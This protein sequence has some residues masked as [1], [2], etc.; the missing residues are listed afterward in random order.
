MT[1]AL[2]V[3]SCDG[4]GGLR[5]VESSSFLSPA[6]LD[7]GTR[8][9]GRTHELTT[10]LSNTSAE[11]LRVF[12]VRLTP[13]ENVY[14]ARLPTETLRGALLPRGS[15]NTV[16]VIFNPQEERSYDTTLTIVFGEF[17]VDLPITASAELIPP[18]APVLSPSRI[19]FPPT[20]VGRDVFQT[21]RVTN[22]GQTDGVLKTVKGANAPFSVEA[23]GGGTLILPS[24]VLRPGGTRDLEVHFRPTLA[25]QSLGSIELAF[26]T[27]ELAILEVSGEGAAAGTM[28]CTG[29]IDFGAV[30]RGTTA[31][32]DA[33]CRVSGGA[34]TLREVRFTSASSSLFRIPVVPA[35]VAGDGSLPFQI[36]FDAAG[37][38]NQHNATIEIVAEHGAVTQLNLVGVV[39]PP[40]PG[41]TDMRVR[42]DWNT[43]WSD[44]DI[45]LVRNSV[46]FD[47]DDDCYFA[48]KNPDWGDG[49][50][51]VDDPFL[52][53]DDVDGFGPEE[54][55]LT[56]VDDTT[57]VYDLWVQYHHYSRSTAPP[58]TVT[59]T[60]EIRNFGPVVLTR[61]MVTCGNIWHVGQFRFDQPTP[62]FN[63][64]DVETNDYQASAGERCR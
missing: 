61:D 62:T 50:D 7:F 2:V 54:I 21:L 63:V 33:D 45:H 15:R 30:P 22:G 19:V 20:E 43:P 32:R 41:T 48:H 64:I 34:Y 40:L 39:D 12:D 14:S 29:P 24:P 47:A 58:T 52:D 56:T 13:A 10:E 9:I 51:P 53:R 36:T 42:M 38:A 1:I 8:T 6:S 23:E 11:D 26:D 25:I 27:G 44:F 37:L 16:S 35:I 5:K 49:T 57:P 4:D 3:G 46:P 28:T 55:S 31:T 59:I 60:A 17:E 18:A